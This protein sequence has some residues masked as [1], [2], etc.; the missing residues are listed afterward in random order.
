MAAPAGTRGSKRR[1]SKGKA[2]TAPGPAIDPSWIIIL[3]TVF[4]P[5]MG[6]ATMA[7]G[8]GLSILKEPG[9]TDVV[10]FGC[11]FSTAS[12]GA[13]G[14]LGAVVFFTLIYCRILAVTRR[15]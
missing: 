11:K 2:R 12:V 14:M 4:T 5:I 10:L 1:S 3:I 6:L 7:F 13:I 15:R 9:A 8:L